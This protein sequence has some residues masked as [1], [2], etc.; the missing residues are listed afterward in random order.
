MFN[1]RY[2]CAGLKLT[3]DLIILPE[4][5]YNII[6]GLSAVFMMNFELEIDGYLYDMAFF[7]EANS[8]I[9][10]KLMLERI[11]LVY[12]YVEE[13]S[14]F[15]SQA[16]TK[17]EQLCS[18]SIPKA[19]TESMQPSNGAELGVGIEQIHLQSKEAI[20]CI[21]QI[22]S[23]CGV[24]QHDLNQLY[25]K[26]EETTK[27]LKEIAKNIEL[28]SDDYCSKLNNL[29]FMLEG[30]MEAVRNELTLIKSVGEK[31]D[32][33]KENLKQATAEYE[34]SK[35]SQGHNQVY[36]DAVIQFKRCL[37][38]IP[39]SMMG[40]EHKLFNEGVTSRETRKKK[41]KE[42]D[43]LYRALNCLNERIQSREK[44]LGEDHEIH[45]RMSVLILEAKSLDL[46]NAVEFLDS[47]Q[48]LSIFIRE[49]IFY[50][51][52]PLVLCG[53]RK[54]SKE[55]IDSFKSAGI[56]L[57]ARW[58]AIQRACADYLESSIKKHMDH[59]DSDSD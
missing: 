20:E 8:P 21:N 39:E 19:L 14:C 56:D 5:S 6:L 15:V 9:V 46:Q 2:I 54:M 42:V 53:L 48:E 44:E 25:G 33:L 57:N 17:I 36:R 52:L 35:R 13:G 38:M 31:R 30:V 41:E 3:L 32:S 29:R 43:E 55:E 18:V 26:V 49:H 27:Q 12:R 7:P 11:P 16:C 23:Y 45:P 37:N 34:A 28:V 50:A 59:E 58:A 4:H 51:E 47:L 10:T 24:F 22:N 1:I 40:P